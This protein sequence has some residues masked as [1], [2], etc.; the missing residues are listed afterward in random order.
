M[1]DAYDRQIEKQ[2]DGLR[3]DIKELRAQ[4]DSLRLWQRWVL[5]ISTGIGLMFGAYAKSIGEVLRHV[6]Q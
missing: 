4:V 1:S 5:G 2:I 3:A 6:F